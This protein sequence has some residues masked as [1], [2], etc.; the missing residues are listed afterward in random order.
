VPTVSAATATTSA[1]RTPASLAVKVAM[2]RSIE[3]V[4]KT[5][6][7]LTVKVE[8]LVDG[9]ASAADEPKRPIVVGTNKA[10]IASQEVF[11]LID[12]YSSGLGVITD[13]YRKE[14]RF[15]NNRGHGCLTFVNVML[16]KSSH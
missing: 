7:P 5:S 3:L 1:D 15:R 9:A 14:F 11:L 10:A 13:Y 6:V 8:R 12:I 16:L 4:V 2:S